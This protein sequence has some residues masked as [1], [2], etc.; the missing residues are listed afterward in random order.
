MSIEEQV[1]NAL[2]EG[3]I[4]VVSVAM[5]LFDT[6]ELMPDEEQITINS[7]A[8]AFSVAIEHGHDNAEIKMAMICMAIGKAK[9]IRSARTPR[10]HGFSRVPK[11]I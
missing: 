11:V 7:L 5:A 10:G 1:L 2:P 9:E 6:W 3:V 4:E 8:E